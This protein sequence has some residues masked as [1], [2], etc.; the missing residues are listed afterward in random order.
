MNFA[1]LEREAARYLPRLIEHRRALHRIPEGGYAE[2]QTQAYILSVLKALAPDDLRAFADT[3]V[4]AV[5]RGDGTGRSIAFRA[6]MDA[7]PVAEETGL[8]FAS[9]H[10]GMMHACGH[11]GHM[12]NL[13]TFAEWL[14]DNRASLADT[15]TLL[16]QPAEET[17]GGAKRMIDEGALRDPDVQAIYGMHMMPDVPTGMVATCAGPMMAQ[18]C[19]MDIVISGRS[20]HGATP[21]LGVDAVAAM[22]HLLTLMQTSVARQI[23]P[24]KQALLTIGHVEAGTQRNVLASQA[25]MEGIARTLSNRVYEQL[26]ERILADIR[27]VD[28]AFG[29]R[30]EF[31]KRVFYPCVENDE[32]EFERI[33]G[34]LGERFVPTAP[35]MIAEDFS[36]YQLSVPG[37]FVFCGCKDEQ[38][39][40]P[41]HACTF[42]FDE[43]ALV[44]GLALFTGLVARR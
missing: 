7:L 40:A 20:V 16:F 15:V 3:G 32:A 27:A 17:T 4:R 2:R 35:R 29:T 8:P 9:E 30:T 5:F 18:T 33:R 14:R 24:C 39:S 12:A 41:L 42:D 37:V 44:T 26:E 38:H 13:L 21:H 19:E 25:R 31:I 23:D 11:D 6:D 36:Y 34:I 1:D 22:G 28:A 43:T 10:P